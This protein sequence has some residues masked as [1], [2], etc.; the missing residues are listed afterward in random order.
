MAK[1]DETFVSNRILT[2]PVTVGMK[3]PVTGQYF[4]S[5]LNPVKVTSHQSERRVSATE[6]PATT[7]ATRP[8]SNLFGTESVGTVPWTIVTTHI[9][10]YR[11]L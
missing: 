2:R 1:S 6:R 8:N 11:Q 9:T 5:Q 10:P 4:T 3:P 7:D